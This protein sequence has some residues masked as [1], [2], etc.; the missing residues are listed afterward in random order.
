M[1]WHTFKEHGA[2]KLASKLRNLLANVNL[3]SPLILNIEEGILIVA[4]VV[5]EI[6]GS[7]VHCVLV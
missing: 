2:N 7:T 6:Y 1:L 4:K 5:P 3:F